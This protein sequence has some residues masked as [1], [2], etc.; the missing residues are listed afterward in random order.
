MS[1]DTP[2]DAREF[3]HHE[4][5]ETERVV[6]ELIHSAQ[7]RE[8]GEKPSARPCIA[9][10]PGGIDGVSGGYG[11]AKLEQ[12]R[13]TQGFHAILG[14][15]TGAAAAAY[16][17]AEK[18]NIGCTI[19]PEEC[20][21]TQFFDLKRRKEGKPIMDVHWLVHTV[22]AG[23]LPGSEHKKL[24]AS[25][26]INSEVETYFQ[27]RN[28]KTGHSELRRP[29]TETE[30]M[31]TLEASMSFPIMTNYTPVLIDGVQYEDAGDTNPFPFEDF[32]RIA[33]PTSMIVFAN[34]SKKYP[35]NDALREQLITLQKSRIPYIVIWADEIDKMKKTPEKLRAAGEHFADH[36]ASLFEK[37][38]R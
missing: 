17:A 29:R 32:S 36:V 27:I 33:R 12:L 31:Q 26:V 38:L 20:T 7:E 18:A 22:F 19:Y 13:L 16:G 1:L 14:S 24:N 9:I 2:R 6:Y 10:L 35:P 11:M 23:K 30:L 37:P 21:G 34:R 28:S 3:T 15:S 5:F 25:R 4:S 8:R